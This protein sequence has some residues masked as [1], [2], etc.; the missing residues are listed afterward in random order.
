MA[1]A[2]IQFPFGEGFRTFSRNRLPPMDSNHR[3]S[4]SERSVPIGQMRSAHLHGLSTWPCREGEYGSITE[5]LAKI[6]GLLSNKN[7]IRKAG[8]GLIVVQ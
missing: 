4:R 6:S 2:P 7:M 8:E 5:E 3:F 1:T